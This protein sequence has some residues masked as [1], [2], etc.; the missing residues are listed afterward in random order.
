MKNKQNKKPTSLTLR[1]TTS[2]R[3][4]K[5]KQNTKTKETIGRNSEDTTYKIK[6]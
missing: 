4:R 1:P 3:T 5:K 2:E 6:N